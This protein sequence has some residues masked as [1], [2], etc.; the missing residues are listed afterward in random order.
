MRK[1]LKK[2]EVYEKMATAS[3][4]KNFIIK[5]RRTARRVL[6]ALESPKSKIKKPN[7]KININEDFARSEELLKRLR[8]D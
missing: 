4:D 7:S 5:D 3:F 6:K 8:S 2:K 1:D